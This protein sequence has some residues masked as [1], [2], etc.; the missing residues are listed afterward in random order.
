[1]RYPP[2]TDQWYPPIQ[3]WVSA[4]YMNQWYSVYGINHHIERRKTM[5]KAHFEMIL[6]RRELSPE[7]ITY[8]VISS[9]AELPASVFLGSLNG[10]ELW[11]GFR[12]NII[13]KLL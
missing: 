7:T 13:Y 12:T 10:F 2:P 4:T 8:R 1:M 9:R 6:N 5:T 3:S 11:L